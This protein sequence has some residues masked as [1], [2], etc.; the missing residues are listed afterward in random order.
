MVATVTLDYQN[1]PTRTLAVTVDPGDGSKA[2]VYGRDLRNNPT[3]KLTSATASN[4]QGGADLCYHT[5]LTVP[6]GA[7]VNVDLQAFVD[8][9]GRTARSFA[10]VKTMEFWL[11]GSDDTAAGLTGNGCSGVTIEPAASN[12]FNMF[13]AGT[14]PQLSL[15][16]GEDIE[17]KTRRAAGT[18][19]D[20]THK[21]LTFT[22]L[23]GAIDAHVLVIITGGST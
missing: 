21:V 20:A 9:A 10:R 19:V 1:T 18:V 23:D 15:A 8:V 7:P 5:I 13:L 3:V 17:W 12:G 6:V 14:A 11:L 16:N 22:D 4:L 2:P